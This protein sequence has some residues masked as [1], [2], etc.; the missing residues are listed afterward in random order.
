[1]S[2]VTNVMIGGYLVK[3]SA[4][5]DYEAVINSGAKID[6]A[7]LVTRDL[8]GKVSVE[9][10]DHM[11]RTGAVGLGAAG[12]VLIQQGQLPPADTVR[13][14]EFVNYFKQVSVVFGAACVIL[15]PASIMRP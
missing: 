2:D 9:M 8:E 13:T 14:E 4:V 12:F 6:G 1:M 15:A 7:V 3:E 11:K 10:T 5:L